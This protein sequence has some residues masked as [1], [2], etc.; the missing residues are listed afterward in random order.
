MD[1]QG[2][3]VT[4]AVLGDPEIKN[5]LTARGVLARNQAQVGAQLASAFELARVA[6]RGDQCGRDSDSPP[7]WIFR[8]AVAPLSAAPI[9]VRRW[10]TVRSRA[11]TSR[12]SVI[13]SPSNSRSAG[14]SSLCSSAHAA[15]SAARS[16]G[17]P[18]CAT[19]PVLVQQR[20]DLIA[21]RDALSQPG[22]RAPHAARPS[23]AARCSWA[24]QSACS[25][26]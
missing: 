14:L 21:Q 18:V 16:P 1:Q 15:Y 25:A 22:G 8:T 11:S 17:I 3:Q 19:I 12:N 23:P 26:E 20:A 5:W 10:S 24:R 6:D 2:A 7:P 4:V 13:S 9:S